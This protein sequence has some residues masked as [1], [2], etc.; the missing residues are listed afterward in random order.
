MQ[1]LAGSPL[2]PAPVAAEEAEQLL[3]EPEGRV[4]RR[5]GTYNRCRARADV[6]R[7]GDPPRREAVGGTGSQSLLQVLDEEP[8]CALVLRRGR[9]VARRLAQES[10]KVSQHPAGAGSVL[11]V[12]VQFA[13]RLPSVVERC[14]DGMVRHRKSPRQAGFWSYGPCAAPKGRRR[15]SSAEA[16]N[17]APQPAARRQPAP[18]STTAQF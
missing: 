14:R 11:G 12:E 16:L 3:L 10:L 4:G 8:E 6:V 18:T 13:H 5:V 9:V 7:Q 17:E 2:E 1:H 15:F